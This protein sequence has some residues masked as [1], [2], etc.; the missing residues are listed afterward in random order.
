MLVAGEDPIGVARDGTFE[1]AVVVRILHDHVE[2]DGGA[3][4]VTVRQNVREEM[5]DLGLGELELRVSWNAL[6][7]PK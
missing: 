2:L 7:L 4:D 3:D 6:Q 5:R 1:N